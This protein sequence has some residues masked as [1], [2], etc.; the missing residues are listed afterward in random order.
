LNRAPFARLHECPDHDTDE[1][2]NDR[3][4]D[5]DNEELAADATAEVTDR[6]EAQRYDNGLESGGKNG[7]NRPRDNPNENV[8]QA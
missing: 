2:T 6:K 5:S 1:P 4:E 3:A 8:V 7:A